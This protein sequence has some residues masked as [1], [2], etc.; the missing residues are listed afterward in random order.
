[1]DLRRL[2]YFVA[3]AEELHFGRAA[4]RLNVS[5]PPLSVQIRTLERE[6]GA[7][8]LMRTQRRV[9][10]TEAGRVLLDEARRLLGQAE[11]A[12]I[13]ARR[14]AL[15]TVG[16]LTVG[17]VS[18]VDYSILPPL[19]RRFRQKHPGVALKLLEL[20]GDRQQAL[21]QSGE[22]DLGLS[23]LPSPAPGLTTRPVFREPL[24]A[25]VPANHR[26]AA[27]RRIALRALTAEPFIQFP[28]EFA[29]GLYDLAIAA[30]QGAGFT[31][32][33]AQEAIQMQTI[34]GL[35]A[36]GLGVAVVPHCM[37]KLQRPDVRY[38]ALDARGFEVKT[39]ALWHA[40]NRAPALESLIAELPAERQG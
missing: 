37:S 14:A 35:V 31:P 13:H 4:R 12:V 27:R 39:V 34:L 22:L 11:A 21:L 20:T 19:V 8:L 5:Q 16:R 18:T 25:G 23:I 24:I 26:L 9:E 33:L 32:H 38:L 10:L 1:M 7:P 28:R 40:E 30:C 3:V 6:V 2:R 36:A 15:G 17:F 29:P